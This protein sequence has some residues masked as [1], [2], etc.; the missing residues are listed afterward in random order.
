MNVPGRDRDLRDAT[1][2]SA[3]S[4]VSEFD[5]DYSDDAESVAT[6]HDYA[7]DLNC[8]QRR[9]YRNDPRVTDI[10]HREPIRGH[11]A[12]AAF[13]LSPP[14]PGRRPVMREQ[15]R[16]GDAAEIGGAHH[17]GGRFANNQVT[18][19]ISPLRP[20]NRPRGEYQNAHAVAHARDRH[21]VP[22]R[23]GGRDVR[24]GGGRGP[25]LPPF[26]GQQ[27]Q[28]PV[29]RLSERQQA[30]FWNRADDIVEAMG[31]IPRNPLMYRTWTQ[32]PREIVHEAYGERRLQRAGRLRG[33]LQG[34]EEVLRCNVQDCWLL[35]AL[36]ASNEVEHG[37]FVFEPRFI[38]GE[39]LF[40]LVWRAR[41]R[42]ETFPEVILDFSAMVGAT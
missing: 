31:W 36:E 40:I 14:G 37:T 2:S 8:L 27:A 7:E 21:D 32:D 4:V 26:R 6:I 34:L 28:Q 24:G 33:N 15:H 19:E 29:I 41:A 11:G 16:H 22:D 5:V 18:P 35:R 20:A 10:P 1:R 23:H 42:G 30:E 9:E 25:V 39:T 12:E 13:D 3:E 17:P 38:Q